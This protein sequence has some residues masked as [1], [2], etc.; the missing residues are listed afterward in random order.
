[1]M[2]PKEFFSSLWQ[3]YIEVTPQAEQ[4]RQL[5]LQTDPQVIND[6][7][8]FRTFS[9]TP[10]CLAQ[11]QPLILAMGY[12][13][14]ADYNFEAKKL[15]AISFIHPDP[16]V[17]KVF[18][19][20]LE[21]HKLSEQAQAI[22]QPYC[23]QIEAKEL[24]QSVFWSGRHWNMPSW[25]HYQTLLEESEYAAWLLVMGIR[26]NHFT[27]SVDLL[28]STDCIREVLQR[29]EDAGYAI[30]E[31]GGRVKG[32]PAD[33]LEQGS[34][35]ADRIDVTFAGGDSHSVA[36]CFYEFAKRHADSDG[37]LYQGFIAANADKIFESTNV[38]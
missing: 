21:R 20:E 13:I 27:V 14:Q 37:Q 9:D 34:T 19:S 36:S 4:I 3:D 38:S 6:H 25:E 10:L 29:V 22:L 2:Q 35:M 17:P 31:A 26:V 11:L 33:L 28:E 1:M 8:A 5:F 7:V 12:E 23:D 15:R 18:I 30:N 24:E 32:V 16:T